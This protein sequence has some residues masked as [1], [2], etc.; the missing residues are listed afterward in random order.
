MKLPYEITNSPFYTNFEKCYEVWYWKLN[1]LDKK[2][3]FW[4]RFTILKSLQK[5]IIEVWG[6]FTQRIS[7]PN[8]KPEYSLRCIKNTFELQKAEILSEKGNC[9][10]RIEKNF[11]DFNETKGFLKDSVGFIKWELSHKPENEPLSHSFLPYVLWKLGLSKNYAVTTY[12]NLIFNGEIRCDN[13]CFQ[14]ENGKGMQGHLCGIRQG[15]SWAWAHGNIF[16][17]EKTG[18]SVSCIV[19]ILTARAKIGNFLVSPPIS[20]I[21]INYNNQV[22]STKHIKDIL[23]I[24]SHYEPCKWNVEYNN[25]KYKFILNITAENPTI[26][27]VK[28]EDTDGSNLF[29]Y[30]SKMATIKINIIDT[31]TN[32]EDI[33]I[34]PNL[35]AFEWVQRNTWDKGKIYI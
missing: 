14:V 23:H 15:H 20:S 2:F 33:L 28:Y 34:S 8:Q 24:Q 12:E 35:S 31:K 11:T 17:S 22:F 1:S 9:S 3:A 27:G 7:N 30:N 6:I 25:A 13:Q 26:A 29:C 21:F 5:S 4:Y 32:K 16:Y 18:E 19:D 10:I